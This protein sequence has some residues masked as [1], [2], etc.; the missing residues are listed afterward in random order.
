MQLR[1]HP[2][3]HYLGMRNWPPRWHSRQDGGETFSGELGVLTNVVACRRVPGL[4]QLPQLHLYMTEDGTPY[5]ATVLF[6]DAT[7]C[8]GLGDLLKSHYGRTLEGIGAL[9]VSRLS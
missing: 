6:S 8:A 1:D 2:L 3:L 5:I 9:D 4:M 7:F